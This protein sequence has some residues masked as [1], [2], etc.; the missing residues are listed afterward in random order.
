[1]SLMRRKVAVKYDDVVAEIFRLY[2]NGLTPDP[3]GIK[4]RICSSCIRKM[5][6]QRGCRKRSYKTHRSN[7]QP[8]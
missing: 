7:I 2:P 8:L 6:T 3:R 4:R 1:M 5:E